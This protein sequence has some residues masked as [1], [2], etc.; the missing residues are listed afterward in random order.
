MKIPVSS[1]SRIYSGPVNCALEI[2]RNNGI[3]G[4]YRGTGVMILRDIPGYAI[5]LVPYFSL[6]HYLVKDVDEH[7]QVFKSLLASIVAGGLAGGL[8]WGGIHPIYTVKTR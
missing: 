4:L 8:S 3:R 7:Q 5:Y 1:A 2:R 6:R